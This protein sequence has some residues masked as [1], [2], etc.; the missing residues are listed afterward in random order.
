M[1]ILYLSDTDLDKDSGVSKKILMQANKWVE[2]GHEVELFSWDSLSWYSLE[3]NRLTKP[4]MFIKRRKWKVLPHLIL[5]SLGILKELENKKYDIIYM[6]YR[7]F[8]PFFN[9][10][11]KHGK[12]I[13]EINTNDKEEFKKSFLLDLYNKTTR[14]LFLKNVDGFVCVSNELKEVFKIYNRPILVI[15]NGIDIKRYEFFKETSNFKPNLVFIG[16]PNQ[17]WHGVEKIKF[18][19]NKLKN[20]HFHIIGINGKNTGNLT[21]Y[22][23]VDDKKAR[24]LVAKMDIG[25]STLS[26]YINNMKE[27]SPLKSRQ[28]LAQGLPIIYAYNDTDIN[29]EY[30]FCYKL[31]NSPDN[32]K[33]HIR[34]IEKFILQVF[35]KEHIREQARIYAKRHLD[36]SVKETKRLEFFK[37]IC[38]EK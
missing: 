26:L 15:A 5:S 3:G 23:Y 21:Y 14:D 38:N 27:A 30:S 13:V 28:Y 12:L 20:F 18:L 24:E 11:K 19:A 37:E 22:G 17:A 2:L 6:R 16:S 32:V 35:K 31:P 7:L 1:K 36:I 29:E 10:I 34:N 4:K 9:R 25:I 33:N 8:S